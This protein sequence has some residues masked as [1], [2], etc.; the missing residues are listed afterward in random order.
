MYFKSRFTVLFSNSNVYFCKKDRHFSEVVLIPYISM[1]KDR[2]AKRDK[3][4]DAISNDPYR[5]IKTNPII[6]ARYDITA[7]QM[8]VFLKIISCID[9]SK[10][11]ISDIEISVQEVQ[12]FVGKGA[13]NIHAYLQEELTKLRKKEIFY[14]DE[15]IRLESNFI[16]SI[17]YHKKK[18]YFTFE[19]PKSLKPFLL[20]IKENFTVID[21]RN[22]LF[23][24]SVY[25]IRFYEF[26]KEFERFG[27][28][29][30]DVDQLKTMFGLSDR[31]KNYFDFKLKVLQQARTEL[32]KHSELYFDFEEIK[33]G[34]KVVRLRF[35]IIKNKNLQR[36]GESEDI[37]LSAEFRRIFEKVSPFVSESA[38]LQW[39]EKYPAEQIEKSINYC[40][41]QLDRGGV[42]DMGAYLQKMV[43]TPDFINSAEVTDLERKKK[44]ERQQ[45]VLQ[46]QKSIQEQADEIRIQ[47]HEMKMQILG[48]LIRNEE[49]KKE[50]IAKISTGLFKN[51]YKP[52]LSFEENIESPAVA[53]FMISTA[54]QLYSEK[55]VSADQLLKRA[56]EME[57][58]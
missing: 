34:K 44:K 16:N 46:E 21:I 54:G 47:A 14:E 32:I 12:K 17:I 52:Y 26:C 28:F 41:S 24:D 2:Q 50:L 35:T 23:V 58:K 11:D 3:A 25:A 51:Y 42:R 55:F 8:K 20:Q 30:F 38:V 48:E 19:I 18:G 40:F 4:L 9:Q 13:K 49:I 39:F 6:N 27:K 45:A 7:V 1:E 36:E 29:E 37:I 57:K 56:D 33:E 5:L 53:G 43:S 15:N 22:I 10:D 31:Y